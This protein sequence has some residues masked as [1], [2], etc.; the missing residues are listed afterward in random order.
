MIAEVQNWGHATS[1][2][3]TSD[4]ITAPGASTAGDLV[5]LS[6]SSYNS[7]AATLS[8]SDNYG[9]VWNQV[10]TYVVSGNAVLSKWYA[11]NLVYNGSLGNLQITITPSTTVYLDSGAVEY[12]GADTTAP[13]TASNSAVTAGTTTP[14]SG[15]VTVAN[16]NSLLTGAVSSALVSPA[17]LAADTG[18][19]FTSRYAAPTAAVCLVTEDELASADK[20]ATFTTTTS[21]TYMAIGACYKPAV[22]AAPSYTP[23][24]PRT[25]YVDQETL[26]IVAA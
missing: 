17:S 10:G 16:A 22:A 12:S 13:L 26:E 5:E 2:A 20:A 15:V 19:G 6:V 21:S 25:A 4:A 8:I 3:V 24:P 9:N 11:K 23:A 14:T 7:G 18:N 1:S